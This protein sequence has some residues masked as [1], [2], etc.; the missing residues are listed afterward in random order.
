MTDREVIDQLIRLRTRRGITQREVAE[1]MS[2]TP[3]GVCMFERRRSAS[4]GAV[5]AYANAIG[6]RL[7]ITTDNQ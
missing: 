7:T 4:L 2:I 3:A 1:R 5:L 6:A